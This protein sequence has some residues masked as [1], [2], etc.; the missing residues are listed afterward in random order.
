MLINE[1]YQCSFSELINRRR[2]EYAK[3]LIVSNPKLSHIQIAEQ[4]GF[5][6]DSSLQSYLQAIYQHDIQRMAKT[7][8]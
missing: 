2:I 5:A 8:K 1:E 6:H 3:L 7:G 4:S